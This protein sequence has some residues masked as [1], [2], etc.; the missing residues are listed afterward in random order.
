[1]APPTRFPLAL[2]GL[3]AL[4]TPVLGQSP[5]PHGPPAGSFDQEYR[6]TSAVAKVSGRITDL[7]PGVAGRVLYCSREGEVGWFDPATSGRRVIASAGAFPRELRA[8]ALSPSD[9]ITVVDDQGDIYRLPGDALPWVRIYDDLYL[10]QDVTDMI[11][12]ASGNHL[13]ASRTPSSGQRGTNRISADGQRW[14]YYIVRHQP[15]QLAADPLTGDILLADEEGGDTLWLVDSDDKTWPTRV[16]QSGLG[17]PISASRDDGDMAVEADGDVYWIAGGDVWRRRRQDSTRSL[18]AT[19]FEQLRGVTIAP[20]SGSGLRFS[21]TGY[22]LYV[23]AAPSDSKIHEIPGV[24]APADPLATDQGR[25]PGRGT[26]KLF[27]A[28]IQAF[29]ITKDNDDNLLVGGSLYGSNPQVRRIDIDTNAVTTIADASDGLT[30]TIEGITVAPDGTIH[31]TNRDGTIFRITENPTTVTSIYTDPSGLVTAAKDMA[32]DVDGTFYLATRNFWGNGNVISVSG[33][34][35]SVLLTTLEARGLSADPSTGGMFV[36]VWNCAGFC[37]YVSLYDFGDDTLTTPNGFT[38]INYTNDSAW[39]DGDTVVDV[40]GSVY[41][42]SEDDWSVIRYDPGS[43]GFVRIGSSYLNHPSGV[44][45]AKSSPGSNSATGWSLYI[46]E[47][48]FLWERPGFPPPAAT[49]VDSQTSIQG[50]VAGVSH[51]GFGRP[52]DLAHVPSV[53][54]FLSTSAGALLRLNPDTAETELVADETDG[55]HGDLVGLDVRSDQTLVI[56]NREGDLFAVD[57]RTGATELLHRDLGNLLNEVHGLAVDRQDR[58]VI[59]DRAGKDGILVGYD[60]GRFVPLAHSRRGLRTAVDPLTGDFFVTTKGTEASFG[61]LQRVRHRSLRSFTARPRSSRPLA[62]GDDDGDITF[63]A[64]GNLYLTAG[65]AGR[66]VRID[67]KTGRQTTVSGNHANPVASVMISDEAGASLFVL[68]G[69]V[70]YEV[71]L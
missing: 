6:P 47:Y 64:A 62:F 33:G 58:L 1:M 41:T 38:G 8:I 23:A 40:N 34:T 4:I 46:S 61:S 35:G 14:D 5:A 53:G 7:A 67:R 26:Q 69:W 54:V 66:V 71:E 10:I 13:I 21:R 44:A 22:S 24:G 19:G 55:L 60:G 9:V 15:V 20:S 42:C 37:G 30:G 50:I 63:D 25:V 49:R 65:A 59:V 32:L 36:T 39:G 31:A 57:P 52:R 27:M 3:A 11:I 48:D 43:E 45:L 51:P 28:G 56:V 68:D 17:S 12:D 2:F 16:L 29:E 70:I 18:F